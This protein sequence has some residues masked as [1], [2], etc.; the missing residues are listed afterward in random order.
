M[1]PGAEALRNGAADVVR[2]ADVS[3]ADD[4]LV[5]RQTA[6]ARGRVDAVS[7]R[8]TG[9]TLS[10]MPGVLTSQSLAMCTPGSGGGVFVGVGVF[11]ASGSRLRVRRRRGVSVGVGGVVGSALMSVPLKQTSRGRPGQTRVSVGAAS[12]SVL[13]SEGV[14]ANR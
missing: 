1:L 12:A 2:V 8:P 4:P 13:N 14:G 9:C 10:W 5:D 6:L 7:S 3:D 11:V